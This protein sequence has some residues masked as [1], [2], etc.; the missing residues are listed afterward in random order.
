M[1]STLSPAFT[2]SKIKNMLPLMVEV[3]EQMVFSLKKNIKEAKRKGILKFT[4]H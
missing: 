4:T 1:R 2:S 3:G